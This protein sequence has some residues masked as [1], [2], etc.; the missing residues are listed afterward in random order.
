MLNT[1]Y[2]YNRSYIDRKSKLKIKMVQCSIPN[3]NINTLK[4]QTSPQSIYIMY[5]HE[6][7]KL[8]HHCKNQDF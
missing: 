1:I 2:N 6:T 4:L 5:V 7:I 8:D 3:T